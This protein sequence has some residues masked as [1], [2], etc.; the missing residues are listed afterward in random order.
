MSD[1]FLFNTLT[2][3]KE[4]FTQS[5]NVPISLYTCGP[6]VYNYAHIGNLR[7][8]VF[9]D[10]LKRVL[11]HKGYDI[12]HVMNITDIDDKTIRDAALNNI[13][14]SEFTKKYEAAFLKDIDSLSILP[15]KDYPRATDHIDTM[16]EMIS[17]LISKKHAYQGSDGSVY[18]SIS[19]YDE[20][21]RLARLTKTANSTESRIA[22]DEYDKDSASDFVL[23]K[24]Y[25]EKRDGDVFYNAP[26][27]KGRPGWHIECSAMAFK[28]LGESIDI[29]CG[30]VDN[31]FPHHENEIAQSQC[32]FDTKF[33]KVWMHAEHLLVDGKKMSKT[34][35]NFYTLKDI[36]SNGY[37]SNEL[38]YFLSS[39]HY[40]MQCNFTFIALDA[41]RNSLRRVNDCLERL[42]YVDSNKG[43]NEFI[44][45]LEKCSDECIRSIYDDLNTPQCLAALFECIRS[46]NVYID[47]EEISKDQALI[48]KNMLVE[49]FSLLG[50]KVDGSSMRVSEEGEV[51]AKRRDQARLEK[52]YKESDHIR[53][54]LEEMGYLVE[55]TPHGTRVKK[56]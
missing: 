11:L 44:G 47:R 36:H 9:E 16:I 29:H 25:D 15:A 18:F 13:P 42:Q 30:G 46:I 32:C 41:A 1:L 51:L 38:R 20:Y 4:A 43:C 6:T 49:M 19:S 53:K 21:G 52:N 31:M 33:A 27:G 28:I 54:I 10:I 50:V 12:H 5:L 45:V 14:L 7:T 37:S 40:K 26:F 8:Y 35:G 39:Q 24:A 56:I 55:D 48:A 17:T 34:L 3:K 22:N 23:W 2:R